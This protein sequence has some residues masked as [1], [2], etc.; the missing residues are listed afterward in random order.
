MLTGDDYDT[1]PYNEPMQQDWNQEVILPQYNSP[2]MKKLAA[3]A[4]SPTSFRRIRR[5][6]HDECC[7]KSCTM[8]ELTSYCDR[9][10]G[11]NSLND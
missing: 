5:G 1:F 9:N 3:A 8:N 6:I 11:Y 2:F 4:L 7:R 10:G